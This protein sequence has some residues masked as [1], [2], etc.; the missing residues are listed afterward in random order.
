MTIILDK[1]YGDKSLTDQI[2]SGQ[3]DYSANIADLSYIDQN[4]QSI[5]DTLLTTINSSNND[6][7]NQK[8]PVPEYLQ[9]IYH[10]SYLNPRN[11]NW[12]DR[13]PIV[14]SILWWQHKKLSSAVFSEIKPAASV[15]QVA[16]VYGEFSQNLAR[17]IGGDGELKLVDV[18]P[19]QVQNTRIKLANYPQAEVCLGDAATMKDKC[20]DVVLCYFLLH[21]IP[22]DYKTRVLDNLLKHIKPD[23]KLVIVDYHKPH[24]A[25]PVKPI[26]SLI[27]D[28]L[29]PFAKTLWRKTINDL[30]TEPEKYDWKFDQYFGGLYQR[31]VIQHKSN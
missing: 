3:S 4:T 5:E 23:G 10:W 8:P 11:V 21:E 29:E 9:E 14:K 7:L 20:Y 17:H 27:F 18:A 30:T 12:L 6:C 15:M 24:W 31:V 16:A 25:H 19:I 28:F 13:E 2:E 22:D 1:K 26:T